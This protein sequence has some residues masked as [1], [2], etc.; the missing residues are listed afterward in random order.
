[1]TTLTIGAI[2]FLLHALVASIDGIYFHLW[3]YKLHTYEDTFTEHITHTL[4]T[5]T[6]VLA[7]YLLFATNTGG[8]LLWFAVLVL[9]VDLLVETWDV[10]IEGQSRR[11]FGGLSSAEYL[12][13]AHSIFLYAAAWTLAFVVKPIEA[14]SL[15]SP[16]FLD[17]AYPMHVSAIGWAVGLGT[18]S[19]AIQHTWY[20]LPR[21]RNASD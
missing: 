6:M 19:G 8:A 11:R 7:S 1:M 15:S 13:H 17:P 9:V 3:K 4:R 16:L 21:Y 12:V 10:L 2:L 18:L 5:W 14:W 20:C